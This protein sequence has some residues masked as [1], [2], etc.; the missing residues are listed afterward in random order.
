[1]FISAG[2]GGI[3]ACIFAGLVTEYSHPK[4]VFFTYS[5]LGL[6]VSAFACRLTM[7]SEL[8]KVMGDAET[9]ISTS[10][11]SYEYMVRRKRIQNGLNRQQVNADIRK[12][13]GFCFNLMKNCQAIGRALSHKEI[14]LLVIFFLL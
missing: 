10:Q 12:R 4:W 13:E 7:E 5:F 14:Y 9:V 11:E 2:T 6:A 1:M 3:I 8:D